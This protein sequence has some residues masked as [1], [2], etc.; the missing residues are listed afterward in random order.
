MQV[1]ISSRILLNSKPKQKKNI[2]CKP[3]TT[4]ESEIRTELV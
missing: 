2:T 3:A 4:D 1:G